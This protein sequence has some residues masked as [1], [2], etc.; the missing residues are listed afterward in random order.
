MPRYTARSRWRVVLLVM[1]LSAAPAGASEYGRTLYQWSDA[2]GVV[3]YTTYPERVPRDQRHTLQEVLANA[4]AEQNARRMDAAVADA[5]GAAAAAGSAGA[6]PGADAASGAA[7]TRLT[8]ADPVARSSL[9]ASAPPEGLAELDRRIEALELEIERDEETVKILI[10]DA[11][12]S[13]ATGGGSAELAEIARRLPERQAELRA[14]R[15]QREA[16][17]ADHG[18]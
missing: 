7:P 9:S 5:A 3:R 1:A 10:S 17:L 4:S 16:L 15:A 13:P 18:S 14:L 11:R 12:E 2:E 6:A 8:A